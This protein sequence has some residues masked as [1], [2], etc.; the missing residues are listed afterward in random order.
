[1]SEATARA[2]GR[3]YKNLIADRICLRPAE[4]PNG[5]LRVDHWTI[6][7]SRTTMKIG[8][9]RLAREKSSNGMRLR[10]PAVIADAE[11]H[12]LQRASRL[13]K[14]YRGTAAIVIPLSR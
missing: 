13:R 5:A 11:I 3:R 8:M 2:D 10:G 9:V 1:M 4:I 6:G 7:I 14:K 12:H